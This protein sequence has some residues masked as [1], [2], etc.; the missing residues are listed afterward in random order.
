MDHAQEFIKTAKRWYDKHP[1][2]MPTFVRSAEVDVQSI[3]HVWP[4][5]RKKVYDL[6][7]RTG[8]GHPERPQP[9]RPPKKTTKRLGGLRLANPATRGYIKR[10]TM[11]ETTAG[12]ARSSGWT[13]NQAYDVAMANAF[14]TD[15]LTT[16][17]KPL[18]PHSD[19]DSSESLYNPL[20]F[21]GANTAY[22]LLVRSTR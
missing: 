20:A 21:P 11:Y 9:P 8:R 7:A 6:G 12:V 19:T 10:C 14:N 15:E 22:H 4:P 17:D 18:S 13:P 1:D 5:V 2:W 3:P 16:A